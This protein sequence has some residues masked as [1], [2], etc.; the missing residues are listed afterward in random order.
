MA[1]FGLVL[2][3]GSSFGFW[4]IL[5]NVD[6]R[7]EYLMAARTFERWDVAGAA[8][9]TTVEANV[10]AAS[11]IAADQSGSV[12]G[13]WATGRIPA[14]TIITAGLFETPPLSSESEADKVWMRVTLPSGDIPAGSFSSG[15][16]IALIGRESSGPEGA[17][18]ALSLI[19]VLQLEVVRGDELHYI[20]TPQEALQ[21]RQTVDR[22]NQASERFIW[23]LGFDLNAEDVMQALAGGANAPVGAAPGFE[24]V[25]GQG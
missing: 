1:A 9:F 13:R 3:L 17:P 10:G 19:G 4:F 16:T 12:V 8:D 6:Q 15:D 2:V 14:G 21:I 7:G 5:R 25:G 11:A 23:P 22:Y 18:G 20:V 24:P